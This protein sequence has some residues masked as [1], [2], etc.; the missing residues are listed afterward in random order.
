MKRSVLAVLCAM[1]VLASGAV[2]AKDKPCCVKAGAPCACGC[3]QGNKC[4]CKSDCMK[5]GKCACQQKECGC[6]GKKEQ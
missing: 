4:D 5:N 3:E 6:A 2:F 1:L